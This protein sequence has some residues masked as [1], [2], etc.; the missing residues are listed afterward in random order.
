MIGIVLAILGALW[1]W[2]VATKR[3]GTRA[4]KLQYAIVYMLVFAIVG[5]FAGVLVDRMN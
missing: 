4:D 5:L 3:G 1:G 2:R